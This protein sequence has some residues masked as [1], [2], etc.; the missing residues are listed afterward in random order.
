MWLSGVSQFHRAMLVADTRGTNVHATTELLVTIP[1][2]VRE[3][4]TSTSAPFFKLFW[5][6]LD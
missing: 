5:H 2:I 4:S 6:W 1:E 3:S